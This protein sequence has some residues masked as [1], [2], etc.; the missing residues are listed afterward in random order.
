MNT[1]PL[2]VCSPLSR[3]SVLD[4]GSL[5]ISNVTKGDAG[6]Y[7]CAARNQFGVASSDGNLLVKG[8]WPG[9]RPS[10]R[11]TAGHHPGGGGAEPG[12]ETRRSMWAELHLVSCFVTEMF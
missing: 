6:L 1:S 7:T 2:F 12:P 11:V 3:I 5:R 8:T 4:N 10:Y 9:T